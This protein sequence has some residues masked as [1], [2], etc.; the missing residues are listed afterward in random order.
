MNPSKNRVFCRDCNREKLLFKEEKNAINFIKFNTGKFNAVR[1]YYCNV[2]GGW[3]LTSKEGKSYINPLVNKVIQQ[4]HNGYKGQ[5]G[6]Y[7]NAT[8]KM[9]NDVLTECSLIKREIN[10]SPKIIKGKIRNIVKL[11]NILSKSLTAHDF[12][13]IDKTVSDT[14]MILERRY[15]SFELS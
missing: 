12:S 15:C 4:Y 14:F 7:G 9:S 10:M 6:R 8:I 13:L 3:H 1:V 2:C 5:L 11:R